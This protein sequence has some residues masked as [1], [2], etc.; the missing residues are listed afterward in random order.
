VVPRLDILEVMHIGTNVE[1][2]QSLDFAQDGAVP[3]PS[4]VPAADLA[5]LDQITP[6]G[7]GRRLTLVG[8][9]GPLQRLRAIAA[10][11]L[12]PAAFPVR[13]V[14]FNKT[15]GTNWAL[16]W[17]QDRVI[18]VERRADVEGFGPWTC[19]DGQLHVAPPVAVLA[20][21]VTLRV[22]LD[23]CGPDNSPLRVALGSHRLGR[24]PA[25]EAADAALRLPIFECL[26]ERGDVWVYATPILHASDRA[27]R[28]AGRR[29]LQID[30]AAQALPG[31]LA[32]A[33][34]DA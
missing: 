10:D 15:A 6:A 4:A 13:A 8:L 18:A 31:G 25:A 32:W 5:L 7:P 19:K 29:V 23:P 9:E 20:G 30:Y 33:G 14:L 28:P 3:R 17:H 16:G 21:M 22:H 27:R 2:R 24:V 12:G 1:R 34:I 11:V 26:A